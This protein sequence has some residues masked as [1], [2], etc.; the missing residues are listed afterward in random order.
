MDYRGYVSLPLLVGHTR[1]AARDHVTSS[2][3]HVTPAWDHMT[4]DWPIVSRLPSA[5]HE[6][7]PPQHLHTAPVY[8]HSI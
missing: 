8:I 7:N 5:P 1:S 3:S 6:S 4:I 2:D